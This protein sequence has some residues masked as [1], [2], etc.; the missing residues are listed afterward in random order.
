MS[1]DD[2]DKS[3]EILGKRGKKGEKNKSL[4]VTPDEI[5]ALIRRQKRNLRKA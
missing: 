3:E 4:P 5:E 1:D 2:E